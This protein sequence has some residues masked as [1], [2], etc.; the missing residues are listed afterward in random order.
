MMFKILWALDAVV[1]VIF[2][3]FFFLGLGD[4]SVSSFNMGLWLALLGGL[5]GVLF[6]SARLR[7]AG[8]RGLALALL[9]LV[10]F[11]AV[12]FGLFMLIVIVAKPDF[13]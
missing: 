5:A 12:M 2:L 8:Q 13:R 9:A 1:A 10:A 7:A 3:L 4:G 11:P 6:G